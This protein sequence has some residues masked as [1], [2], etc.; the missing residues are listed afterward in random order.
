MSRSHAP[1][2]ARPAVAPYLKTA[3]PMSSS[4][5]LRLSLGANIL[6]AALVAGLCLRRP[7]PHVSGPAI[8]PVSSLP[9]IEA[10][11]SA[12]VPWEDSLAELRRMGVPDAIVARLVIEKVAR[13]W[14]P[15]EAGLEKKYL[16]GEIDARGLAEFHDQRA[17]EQ[18]AELRAALGKGFLAWDIETTVGNMY[19]GGLVPA[20]AQKR[21]LY[22]LQK[23]HLERLHRL[24]VAQRE[25]R[26]AP[27]AFET[28]HAREIFDFKTS[29]AALIGADRVDGLAPASMP[30]IRADFAQLGLD[31]DQMRALA[32]VHEKWSAARADLAHSLAQT[33]SL[34]SAY[35][36]DLR[37]LEQARDEDYRRILG[38]ERFD[39][40]QRAGDDRHRRMQENAA[41]W[42]LDPPAIASV[43]ATLRAYDLA[44]A[45]REYQAQLREQAGESVDWTAVQ[46]E[47]AAYTRDTE[48]SLRARLGEER[49]ARLRDASVIALREPDLAKT[50]LGERPRR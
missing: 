13:K 24:E 45:N 9:P 29:L 16:N 25:G 44:V 15:I 22:D 4:Q 5:L 27:E 26:L 32:G 41:A 23:G 48:T 39:A 28:V 43:Y 46:A 10:A 33:A 36:S 42:K 31:D 34:D 2:P 47:I 19:L 18:E 35:E 7:A 30:Q 14:T 20:E 37:A 12:P 50:A 11:P 40:W 6:L 17:R 38:D 49:F 8:V 1:E 3:T 21:P